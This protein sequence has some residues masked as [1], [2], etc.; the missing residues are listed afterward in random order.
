M[1]YNYQSAYT[2]LYIIINGRKVVFIRIIHAQL[3]SRSRATRELNFYRRSRHLCK[4]YVLGGAANTLETE[5]FCLIL[6]FANA[7]G[8]MFT[9]RFVERHSLLAFVPSG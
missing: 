9:R 8:W 4:I 6:Q 5:R 1:V 3:L 2:Q 7:R